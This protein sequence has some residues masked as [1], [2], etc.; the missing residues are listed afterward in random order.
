MVSQGRQA[1]AVKVLVVC[2]LSLWPFVPAK[3]AA[4]PQ[5][6][7]AE[8]EPPTFVAWPDKGLGLSIDL[9]GFKKEIDQ[10]K[11]DGRRY[12]MASH[13]KTKLDVSIT[14]EKVPTKASAK[15]CLEQLRL[16]QNDSSVT[17]GQDIAL[18]TTGEIPTL[19]Y[20]IQKFRGVRVDQKN[21]YACIAQDNV[22]ADIHLSKAQYTTADAQFF[23]S[24]LKTLRLQPTP[25][26][27]VLPP[28]PAP[29]KEMV[30]LPAPAPPKE[31]V[32]LSPP[33]PPNSKELL[34]MGN[35]LSRQYKYAQALAP[36]QKAFELEK[37]EPQ[38]DRTQWRVLIENLGMAYGMTG[39][40]KEARVTFEQGIQADPTYPMFHYN[41][42]RTF[43][44]MKDLDRAM[45]SLRTAFRHRKNQNPGEKGMPDPYQD[46]S[47]Q[48]FMKNE[49]FR[50]LVND[51]TATKS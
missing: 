37:A 11:P 51:L 48:H 50:N 36:Y 12:L 16:I 21:V 22:Y 4:P 32:R 6:L 14:L 41:L 25:S 42:A 9:T 10:V 29:P 49:T 43:A 17:R 40:L 20:T 26:E 31:M 45:Q 28:A 44:E 23:Q 27:I 19:E 7:A 13:P 8:H 35:A 33:A 46:V 38:L 18:N 47:F 34:N 30:R 5:A 1:D 39:R 2:A 3:L 15:G 24:I